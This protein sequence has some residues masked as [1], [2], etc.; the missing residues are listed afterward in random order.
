VLEKK[1]CFPLAFFDGFFFGF[2][3]DPADIG[4]MFLQIFR[5]F[6]PTLTTQKTVP[7][8]ENAVKTSEPAYSFDSVVCNIEY[9]H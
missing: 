3:L 8:I 1:L 7:S 6:R 2:F 5:P 9:E 4:D